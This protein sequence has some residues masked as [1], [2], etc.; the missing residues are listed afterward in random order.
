[1]ICD[2]ELGAVIC[3][4][5]LL[6]WQLKM[7]DPPR[8]W[9]RCGSSFAHA[10]LHCLWHVRAWDP[11][12]MLRGC[13]RACVVAHSKWN[14]FAY[15]HELFVLLSMNR[16]CDGE[17]APQVW[18]MVVGLRNHD[19][20]PNRWRWTIWCWS[21]PSSASSSSCEFGHECLLSAMSPWNGYG[22][23]THGYFTDVLL[24]PQWLDWRRPIAPSPFL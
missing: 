22:L 2:H 11:T 7:Q 3:P 4:G 5:Y 14:L 24:K 17:G 13:R 20:W 10:R 23:F 19:A 8:L 18:C 9:S 21:L 12:S 15:T 16:Y 6:H 1:M